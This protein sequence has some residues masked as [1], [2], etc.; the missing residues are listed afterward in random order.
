MQF[1]T[2]KV[3]ARWK[4]SEPTV[5]LTSAGRSRSTRRFAPWKHFEPKEA[6]CSSGVSLIVSCFPYLKAS[7][8]NSLNRGQFLTVKALEDW[9]EPP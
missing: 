4:D 7:V 8:F 6:L 9:K 5:T 1:T 3:S 2:A